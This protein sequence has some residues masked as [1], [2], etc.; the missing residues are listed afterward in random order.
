[1]VQ[2][3]TDSGREFD[4]M[5]R[6]RREAR[7]PTAICAGAAVG[8][9]FQCPAPVRTRWSARHNPGTRGTT[10]ARVVRRVLGLCRGCSGSGNSSWAGVRREMTKVANAGQRQTT[11][12]VNAS[13]TS[14]SASVTAAGLT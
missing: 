3:A 9:R 4:R 8:S 11:G 1:M 12:S 7:L 10:P 13:D 5:L 2:P 14:P 6:L